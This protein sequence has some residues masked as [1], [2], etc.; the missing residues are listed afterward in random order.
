MKHL[1]TFI[2]A[3]MLLM[4][5]M[6]QSNLDNIIVG[7]DNPNTSMVMPDTV[8]GAPRQQYYSIYEGG[9]YNWNIHSSAWVLDTGRVLSVDINSFKTHPEALRGHKVYKCLFSQYST[10]NPTAIVLENSIGRVDMTRLSAGNYYISAAGAFPENKTFIYTQSDYTS[11]LTCQRY[12]SDAI[13]CTATG[14]GLVSK[15]SIEIQVY[16]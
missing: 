13:K 15:I 16:Y 10:D 3:S 8:E 1:L 6:S 4:P 11:G 9:V 14:D 7:R 5:L 2:L 12:S